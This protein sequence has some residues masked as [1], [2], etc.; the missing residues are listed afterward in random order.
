MTEKIRILL[1]NDDGITSPG[2]AALE[3]SLSCLGE[4]IIV[5]PD[6]DQSASSHALSIHRP[7][8]VEKIAPNRYSVDGTPTDCINLAVNGLIN[9]KRPNLVV[10]GINKG[11]NVGDDVTYSGTV[12]AAMEGTLLRIPSIAVSVL[13]KKNFIFETAAEYIKTVASFALKKRL[14]KDTF[15]NVN[16]P[17]LPIEKIKGVKITKQG[18][19]FYNEEIIKN[20][21]PRGKPY[22]WIGGDELDY[23][24]IPNSDILSVMNGWISITPINLDFTDYSYLETLDKDHILELKK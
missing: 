13:G 19:R 22:Y 6:R 20:K 4:I 1:S 10:S 7:L 5:A 3:K 21:D 14:P 15:L 9:G 12:S 16:V 18:K 8:R 2:I 17:N 11:A 24:K 23:K